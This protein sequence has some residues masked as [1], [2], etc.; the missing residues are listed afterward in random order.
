MNTE[1]YNQ[2][3]LMNLIDLEELKSVR[4]PLARAAG[5]AR[6]ARAAGIARGARAGGAA[7]GARA[8]LRSRVMSR[9]RLENLMDDQFDL[10]EDQSYLQNLNDDQELE[11]LKFRRRFIPNMAVGFNKVRFN[12]GAKVANAVKLQN[13]EDITDEELENLSEEDLEELRAKLGARIK[14]GLKNVV[15]TNVGRAVGMAKS[16]FKVAKKVGKFFALE[17]LEDD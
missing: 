17:N 13:L 2:N 16:G 7:R 8:M 15:K 3:M 5:A 4:A 9:S 14:S 11:E 12:S 10:Q 1:L 6:G